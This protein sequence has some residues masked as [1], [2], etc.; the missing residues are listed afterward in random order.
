MPAG[1]DVWFG[2]GTN[3]SRGTAGWM[4]HKHRMYEFSRYPSSIAIPI[5]PS[6]NIHVRLLAKWFCLY[7]MK[8][9]GCMFLGAQTT[10]DDKDLKK[11]QNPSTKQKRS[12]ILNNFK[13]SQNFRKQK[14]KQCQQI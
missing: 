4:Q 1:S 10:V 7:K 8:S 2:G 5:D 11:L 9:R 14:I 12:K 13:K 3:P 6:G